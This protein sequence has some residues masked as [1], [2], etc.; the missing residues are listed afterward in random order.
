[1]ASHNS[2]MRARSP[3]TGILPLHLLHQ[4]VMEITPSRMATTLADIFG[5][6]LHIFNVWNVNCSK[7]AL[8]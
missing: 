5:A 7:Y 6:S 2:C 3:V 1:M 8:W 4:T